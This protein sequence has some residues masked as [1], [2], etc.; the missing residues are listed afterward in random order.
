MPESSDNESSHVYEYYKK[1]KLNALNGADND[2]MIR[3]E[4]V[5]VEEGKED[6]VQD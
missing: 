3:I 5:N 2:R 6:A 1:L 4:V